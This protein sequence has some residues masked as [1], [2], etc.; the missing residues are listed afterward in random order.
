MSEKVRD[1]LRSLKK[2]IKHG[3][4]ILEEISTITRGSHPHRWFPAGA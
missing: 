1:N 4:E 2:N 3:K